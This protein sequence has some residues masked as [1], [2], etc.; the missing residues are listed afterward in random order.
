MTTAP[1]LFGAPL[2]LVAVGEPGDRVVHY[3]RVQPPAPFDVGWKKRAAL[4]AA[5]PL[6]KWSA[7]KGGK[8]CNACHAKACRGPHAIR[9]GRA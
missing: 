2:E 5:S 1:T 9:W 4:C 6:F 8:P 7:R 3:I